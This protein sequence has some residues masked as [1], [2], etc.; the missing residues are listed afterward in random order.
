MIRI[1]FCMSVAI[2]A[3]LPPLFAIMDDDQYVYIDDDVRLMDSK[4]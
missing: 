3:I 2:L 1:M 4:F